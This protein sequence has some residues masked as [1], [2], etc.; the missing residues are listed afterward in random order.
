VIVVHLGD[1]LRGPMLRELRELFVEV[2]R[3]LHT[4]PF[5]MS[6]NGLGLTGAIVPDNI[7]SSTV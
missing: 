2:D 1:D 4:P 5:S 3:G 6:A 7:H